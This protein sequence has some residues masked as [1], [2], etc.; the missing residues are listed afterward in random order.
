MLTRY[1]ERGKVAYPPL[2]RAALLRR[3]VCVHWHEISVSTSLRSSRS[4]LSARRV[5]LP[6]AAGDTFGYA[7]A[8]IARSSR[9]SSVVKERGAVVRAWRLGVGGGGGQGLEMGTHRG[10]RRRARVEVFC[11]VRVHDSALLVVVQGGGGALGLIPFQSDYIGL[12][13]IR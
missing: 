10:R 6:R 1:K 2:R 3:G 13:W 12:A 7:R 8:R 4:L 11:G 9:T 5:N